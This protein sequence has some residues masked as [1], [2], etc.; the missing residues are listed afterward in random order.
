MKANNIKQCCS[1]MFTFQLNTKIVAFALA[2]P[3]SISYKFNQERIKFEVFIFVCI[4]RWLLSY[5]LFSLS[6]VVSN[7]TC[8][9][10]SLQRQISKPDIS[11]PTN[12]KR[13]ALTHCNWKKHLKKIYRTHLVAMNKRSKNS[14]KRTKQIYQSLSQI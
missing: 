9:V 3:L 5:P 11:F 8:F 12:R 6:S 2:C 4:V 10:R 13:N 14:N 7:K 1:L